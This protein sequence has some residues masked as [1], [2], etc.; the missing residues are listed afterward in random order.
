[1]GAVEGRETKVEL[2][3][4]LA[5]LTTTTSSVEEDVEEKKEE[6]EG[7]K[8]ESQGTSP[9]GE[10]RET[11]PVRTATRAAMREERKG[12]VVVYVC[13]CVCVCVCV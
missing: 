10:R 12:M 11:S 6:G 3:S 13:V 8:A 7:E 1:M 2:G 5:H 4:V 9:C